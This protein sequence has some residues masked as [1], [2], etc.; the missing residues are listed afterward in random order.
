MINPVFQRVQLDGGRVVILKTEVV[1]EVS[2][3]DAQRFGKAAQTFKKHYLKYSL[4]FSGN[5]KGVVAGIL[6][7]FEADTFTRNDVFRW[8]AFA[9]QNFTLE[10]ISSALKQLQRDTKCPI[11]LITDA[12]SSPRWRVQTDSLRTYHR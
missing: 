8:C 11:K 1:C 12:D 3:S 10:E 7:D 4:T 2:D 6:L 5:L 9:G